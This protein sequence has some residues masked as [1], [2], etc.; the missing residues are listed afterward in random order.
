MY[1]EHSVKVSFHFVKHIL[2]NNFFNVKIL[3]LAI[4]SI[5]L[6]KLVTIEEMG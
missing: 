2:Q 3:C 4:M 5:G 1:H 6:Y